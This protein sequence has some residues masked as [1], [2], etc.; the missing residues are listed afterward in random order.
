MALRSFRAAF[1]T[2]GLA[3]IILAA[4][5]AWAQDALPPEGPPPEGA[6]PSGEAPLEPEDLVLATL[7]LDIASSDY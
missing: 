5:P 1:V 7:A 2:A 4:G 3:A 6:P